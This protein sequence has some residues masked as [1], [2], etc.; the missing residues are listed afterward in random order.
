M[1]RL[2]IKRS[3]KQKIIIRTV[4]DY[5]GKANP[6]ERKSATKIALVLM[7]RKKGVVLSE[8]E[9]E[10]LRL[11]KE[12]LNDLNPPSKIDS[13]GFLPQ[14]TLIRSEIPPSS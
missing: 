2:P 13:T 6:K 1:R 7:G 9:K 12:N 8:E 3:L 5:F 4:E 10:D 11:I 14:L